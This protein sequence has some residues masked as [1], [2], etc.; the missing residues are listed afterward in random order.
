MLPATGM[1]LDPLQENYILMANLSFSTNTGGQTVNGKKDSVGYS[2]SYTR[3][4]DNGVDYCPI[5]GAKTL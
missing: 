2:Y 1:F 5:K 3:T 4:K